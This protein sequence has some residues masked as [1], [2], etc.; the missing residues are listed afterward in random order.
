MLAHRGR[1]GGC[2][3]RIVLVAVLWLLAGLV[4]AVQ[5]QT[6][7][8]RRAAPEQF[9]SEVEASEPRLSPSGR[10]LA[11]YEHTDHE[12]ESGDIL[13][14]RDLDALPGTPDVRA[15]FGEFTIL[16]VEWA[17]EDRVL[18][19]IA[20]MGNVRVYGASFEIPFSRV[21]SFSRATLDDPVVLFEGQSRR[22][23]R[24]LFNIALSDVSD[25][26]PNDPDHI[27]MPAHRGDSLHLWRVNVN[28][29]EAEIAERGSR[30][31][32]L[33]YTGPGGYAV[34]RVDMS[35]GGRRVYV[36]TRDGPNGRWRR[37]ANYRV[38]EL[39]D[40]APEFDW[41][42]SSDNPNQIYIYGRPE[43]AGRTN[44]YLYDL[45]SN[46]YVD[47][48]A[49]H[50]RVDI[51]RTLIDGRTGRYI[52]Y[53]YIE[54]RQHVVF[55]DP[56]LQR[57]Y[58]AIDGFF[59]GD[60]SVIPVSMAGG[61]M[62]F[63]VTGPTEPGVFY[64]YDQN[65][66][67]ID[68][69]Y[70]SRPGLP[71]GAL[72]EVEIINYRTRDG[73]E[74]TGYLT[75]PEG[76]ARETTPLVV[77]PHGGPESRDVY[78]FDPIAQFLA[79]NGYAVFQPNFRGSSGFGEAF[80]RSGY[81]QWGLAMQDDITDG[82]Q[83]LI[84]HRRAGADRICIMGFSYGGYAALMGGAT[85]PD[86][87]QCVIAGASVTDLPAFVNSWEEREE[88]DALTYWTEAIGDPGRD[89][90]RMYNTSPVNLADRYIVPVLLFHGDDDDVVPVA[91]SRAMAEA[92]EAAGIEHH[93]EE[94]RGVGH[95]M[96]PGVPLRAIM[97]QS[98]EFL[99]RSIGFQRGH[100]HPL[101]S[102]RPEIYGAEDETTDDLKDD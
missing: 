97:R 25:L 45:V 89:Y 14:I 34:M 70:M 74:L 90:D 54:D 51:N 75:L 22:V 24:S 10:Y 18:V 62:L 42:G 3:M 36:Y 86:L 84:D 2:E 68:P 35:R 16:W 80:A 77:M 50:D 101:A 48:V 38:N 32:A 73:L 15:G 27:L 17:N 79:M 92:F 9:L 29:G 78:D 40:V 63:Y 26:L 96:P 11:Y 87:Y 64:L 19:A 91:Q 20:L 13:T 58:E 23:T 43:G 98:L 1:C 83:H 67:S 95:N 31:T 81:H 76:G 5:A 60:V 55:T 39:S 8:V 47:T 41:A 99:D 102:F 88:E 30:R 93:Y 59:G 71:L 53:V 28:T 85:T 7:Q 49:S 44:V 37:T 4:Q 94:M 12:D 33:W 82:V 72:A 6:V 52:G 21:L 57:H 56:A 66:A 69:L 61:R 65:A 100:I 46:T